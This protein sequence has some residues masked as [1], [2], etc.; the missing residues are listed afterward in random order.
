[1]RRADVSTTQGQIPKATKK[2]TSHAQASEE[3][4]RALPTKDGSAMM[5]VEHTLE[6]EGEGAQAAK[7]VTARSTLHLA[8]VLSSTGGSLLSDALDANN[9]SCI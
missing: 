4:K 8:R 2:D 3:A 9:F 5:N 7:E 6:D 1:M